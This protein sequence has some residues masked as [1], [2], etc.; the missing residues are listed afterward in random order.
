MK[1]ALV[2]DYIGEFGGAERVLLALSEIYPDAP[3]YTAFT[4]EGTFLEKLKGKKIITSWAQNIPFFA[5]F[6]HS[7]L[8]FLTPL[9]WN[10]FDFSEYD[11][12][13]SSASWYVTKGFGQ[14]GP[15]SSR[16][17]GAIGKP[18]EICYCHTPPRY[19]YGFQTA[20]GFTNSWPVKLYSHIV[21]PFMRYYD[22]VSAQ[23]VSYFIANSNNVSQRIK[24]F[25]R[26]DSTVIYPPVELATSNKRQVTRG[27]YYLIVAR[28]VGAKGIE[29][30]IEAANKLNVPLKIAGEPSGY[31]TAFKELKSKAGENVKFLGFVPD[32]ELAKL[33]AGAKAFLALA[34]DEDFGI[35]PVESMQAG[36]PVIAYKGGGYLETVTDGETGVFFEDY[37]VEGLIEAMHRLDKIKISPSDCKKQGE[38]FSKKVFQEKIREFVQSKMEN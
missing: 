5:K 4:R 12:V 24:K 26:R 34:K 18:I 17:R 11:V 6:L 16:L 13:I 28:I 35:T 3:I 38:K 33:Y 7:P 37:S 14:G 10:S 2:H 30:A 36:T 32:E 29:M 27:N 8:R 23:K 15:T 9:I 25:Y 1:I 31:A 19:L 21:N 22:F 20:A